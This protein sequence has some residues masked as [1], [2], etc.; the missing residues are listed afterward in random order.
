[1]DALGSALHS[2]FV[3]G[4]RPYLNAIFQERGLP[5]IAADSVDHAEIWL[6]EALRNLLEVPFPEQRRS[7]LE[8]VQQ[9]MTGITE[10]LMAAGASKVLRD[11][12][13]VAALPGD[14]YGIAPASSAALGEEAFQAHIAWGVAKAQALAP[15]VS[16]TGRG[17]AVVS[18]DL[19]DISR[20]EE[21]ANGVGMQIRVWG[22][23]DG[24]DPKPVVAF[25]DLTHPAA[26]EAI[27]GF[28]DENVRVIAYGPHVDED[29]LARAGLLGASV[30][31]PRSRLFK[32]IAEYLPRIA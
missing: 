30:V 25:V 6:D 27:R 29:A 2:A 1:M 5:E 26:E 22:K 14:V 3:G 17:V 24:N 7:P 11:P 28:T 31:L 21:A 32:S 13:T 9:A 19:M 16:G 18:S 8:I 4:F 10:A 23:K 12:V 20:F 15:L